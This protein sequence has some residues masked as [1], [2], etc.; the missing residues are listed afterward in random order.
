[1]SELED[2][3]EATGYVQFARDKLINVG[4]TNAQMLAKEKALAKLAEFDEMMKKVRAA[5]EG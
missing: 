2:L 5:F 3:K 4:C 1:M